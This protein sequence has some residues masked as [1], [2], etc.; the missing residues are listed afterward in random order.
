MNCTIYGEYENL[1][2]VEYEPFLDVASVV[3]VTR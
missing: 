3:H 1:S 2:P